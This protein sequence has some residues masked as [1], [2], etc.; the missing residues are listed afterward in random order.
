MNKFT[1]TAVIV[2]I[3]LATVTTPAL[4]QRT[5]AIKYIAISS[6]EG[7]IWEMTLAAIDYNN[8]DEIKDHE[9]IWIT[10]APEVRSDSITIKPS[11]EAI[12]FETQN[13][14]ICS[15]NIKPIP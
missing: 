8:N 14:N 1:V 13:G 2:V 9:I 5:R 12:S 11:Q 4:A 3:G 6:C 15:G 10:G 7:S